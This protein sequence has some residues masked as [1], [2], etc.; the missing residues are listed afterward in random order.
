MAYIEAGGA[1]ECIFCVGG[2]EEGDWRRRLLLRRSPRS[3]VM[4]NKFPYNNG[5]LLIAPRRHKGRLDELS[6]EEFSD[7]MAVLR[8]AV[9]AVDRAFGP[10][11]INVGMNLGR[12]AGAGIE[13][14][15]HWHVVP[16]WEGDTNFMPVVGETKVISQHL[17]ETY[18]RLW[19]VFDEGGL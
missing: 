8:S 16:R 18:D 15:L 2:E 14:H 1:G 11:G 7:L 5:H 3:L 12:C 4:L 19:A 13:A 10:Q 17:M 6:G 9:S